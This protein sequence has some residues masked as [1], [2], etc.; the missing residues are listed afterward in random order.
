M[1]GDGWK[2]KVCKRVSVLAT[3]STYFVYVSNVVYLFIYYLNTN[4]GTIK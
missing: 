1:T 2:G 3:F 4:T